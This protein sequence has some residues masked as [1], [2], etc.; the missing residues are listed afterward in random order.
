IEVKAPLVAGSRVALRG[1]LAEG[2]AE[3][4]SGAPGG[5]R[6]ERLSSAWFTTGGELS[7]PVDPEGVG[8][9]YLRLPDRPGPLRVYLV[10]RDERGGAS[11]V[12]RHL[13]VTAPP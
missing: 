13:I 3:W 1:R 6:R 4:W 11:V 9:T 5:A 8:P 7:A 2:A 10:V 12:E